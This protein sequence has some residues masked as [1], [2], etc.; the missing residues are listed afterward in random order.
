MINENT[1]ELKEN[2]SQYF[3]NIKKLKQEKI[4]K[5]ASLYAEISVIEKDMNSKIYQQEK[6]LDAVKEKY[7]SFAHDLAIDSG[8]CPRSRWGGYL[9]PNEIDID[10]KGIHLTWIQESPYGRDSYDY[11]SAT[12]EDLILWEAKQLPTEVIYVNAN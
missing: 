4:D 10:E 7:S 11:F 3:D 2:V 6:E 12:W 5:T 1:N 9:E 8:D